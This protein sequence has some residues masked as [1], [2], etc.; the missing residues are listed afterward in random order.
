MADREVGQGLEAGA[1]GGGDGLELVG[2]EGLAVQPAALGPLLLADGLP[3]QVLQS[4]QLL[5]NEAAELRD[6]RFHRVVQQAQVPAYNGQSITNIRST[7]TIPIKCYK[8]L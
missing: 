8:I 5:G 4:R 1:G 6:A 7:K 3:V 2:P